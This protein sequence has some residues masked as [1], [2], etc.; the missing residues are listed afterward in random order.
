MA[1]KITKEHVLKFYGKNFKQVQGRIEMFKRGTTDNTGKFSPSA[2]TSKLYGELI[3]SILAKGETTERIISWFMNDDNI[4][5]G[6]IG[7]YETMLY[8]AGLNNN[9]VIGFKSKVKRVYNVTRNVGNFGKICRN[10]IKEGGF[11]PLRNVICKEY[12]LDQ[13][14]VSR[15]LRNTGLT[16]VAVIDVTNLAFMRACGVEC[17]SK[18]SYSELEDK[19]AD[20]AKSLGMDCAQLDLVIKAIRYGGIL[21]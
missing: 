2:F 19:F 21:K 7:M 8:N 20:L 12:T 18:D 15:A 10:A 11:G 3:F 17:S 5:E 6:S 1:K 13:S 14:V 16:N 9:A 4:R